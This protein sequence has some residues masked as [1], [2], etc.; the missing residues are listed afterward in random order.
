[1]RLIIGLVLS[2]LISLVARRRTVGH[3]HRGTNHRGLH[4]SNR[5]RLVLLRFRNQVGTID[6]FLTPV[7]NVLEQLEF[8]LSFDFRA[9]RDDLVE[10]FDLGN[11][12]QRFAIR[13]VGAQ[14]IFPF[15]AFGVLEQGHNL[16]GVQFAW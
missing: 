7:S 8:G 5:S 15:G 6:A 11:E 10:F 4:H 3:N 12:T 9:S 16:I 1:M 2:S 14:R 13:L